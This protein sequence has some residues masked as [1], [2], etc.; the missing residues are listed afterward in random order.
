[1]GRGNQISHYE[2][3]RRRAKIPENIQGPALMRH[4]PEYLTVYTHQGHW[5][6]YLLPYRPQLSQLVSFMA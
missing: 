1:M 5:H 4:G 3:Q 2:F 6:A